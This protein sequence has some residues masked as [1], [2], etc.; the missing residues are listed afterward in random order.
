[1]RD[2][3]VGTAADRIASGHQRRRRVSRLGVRR[4]RRGCGGHR[5]ARRDRERQAKDARVRC[6]RRDCMERRPVL[7]RND[8]R[9]RGENWLVKAETL[10]E[11]NAERQA[12]R[13]ALIVTDMTDGT[14]RLVRY[15]DIDA[16]S[17]RDELAKHL[18]MGK[19]GA[20]EVDS[21][22]LFITVHAPTAR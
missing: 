6:C 1:G 21:K 12:R 14:Q 3:G 2:L 9:V 19:S 16:D 17:L 11:L 8:P 13:P 22:K 18:R 5:G 7:W 4:M 20:I 10:A 15:K